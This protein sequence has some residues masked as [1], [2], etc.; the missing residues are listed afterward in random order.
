M[1]QAIKTTK[2]IALALAMAFTFTSHP[3]QALPVTEN[4][5]EI[6]YLGTIKNQPVFLIDLENSKGLEYTITLKDPTGAVLFTEKTKEVDFSKKFKLD[7]DAAEFRSPS[8]ELI[9]EITPTLTKKIERYAIS[10]TTRVIED[11]VI[12]K[13]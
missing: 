8:F 12:A 4:P 6:K 13:K 3:G 11:V 9:V 2:F 1:K 10:T 5:V 7:I